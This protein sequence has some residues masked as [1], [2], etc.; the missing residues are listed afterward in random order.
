MKRAELK[1]FFCFVMGCLGGALFIAAGLRGES[2]GVW[3]ECMLLLL[4]G[5]FVS[6]IGLVNYDV[7]FSQT[8]HY[9]FVF[10][11]ILFGYGFGNYLLWYDT[12]W[13]CLASAVAYDVLVSLFLFVFLVNSLLRMQG[14]GDYRTP[15][16]CL[17]I[18]WVVCLVVL[19]C[20]YAFEDGV[21]TR[22]G[23]STLLAVCLGVTVFACLIVSACFYIT[24]GLGFNSRG[25]V[26]CFG[27]IVAKTSPHFAFLIQVVFGLLALRLSLTTGD[28]AS[29][30][31]I[32]LYVCGT[33]FLSFD[34]ITYT[35]IHDCFVVGFAV[36]VLL[37]SIVVLRWD[38]TMQRTGTIVHVAAT[39]VCIL[40][41]LVCNITGGSSSSVQIVWLLGTLTMF[42]LFICS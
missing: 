40:F 39:C 14:L 30:L 24:P 34:A 12:S 18:L 11:L 1:P 27:S 6:L 26:N 23:G 13:W 37:F 20:V 16:A 9:S 4:L 25:G 19:M 3:K 22:S 31:A 38:N 32:V 10:S 5:M 28:T 15:Q 17:E 7:G 2:V 8:V 21:S 33:G 29:V 35:T 36:D 42:G 41:A